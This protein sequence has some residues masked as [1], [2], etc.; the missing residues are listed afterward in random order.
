MVDKLK[1][2]KKLKHP[3]LFMHKYIEN[4]NQNYVE[5]IYLLRKAQYELKIIVKELTFTTA[6]GHVV[7]R[8]K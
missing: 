7:E 2:Y 4:S 3:E 6:Q 8:S 1:L 5:F